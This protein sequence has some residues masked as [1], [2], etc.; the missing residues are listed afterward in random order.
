M[1]YEDFAG[2]FERKSDEELLRLEMESGSLTPEATATLTNELA[3]RRI[4]S[5]ER[6]SAFRDGE[7]RREEAQSK[8]P[9]NLFL[10]FRFGIG[11]WYLGKAERVRDPNTGTERF[12]TTVFILLL[13]FPLIPTGSYLVEKQRG[14]G[15]RGI[16][17]L[18]KLPLDW[19]QVL[20]V[21][22]VAIVGLVV[23][24][25]VLRRM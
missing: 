2:S 11:R 23:I 5:A 17:I 1:R 16:T 24:I 12:K 9:G 3:K 6:I 18:K 7:K 21:W 19:K 4:N 14:V 25:S 13:W 10:H 20:R 22:A 8:N 15:S